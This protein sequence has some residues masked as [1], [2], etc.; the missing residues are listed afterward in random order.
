M[1]TIGVSVLEKIA[2]EKPVINSTSDLT[3]YKA[4][5]FK[6]ITNGLLAE[7]IGVQTNFGGRSLVEQRLLV[8]AKR[9]DGRYYFE[10]II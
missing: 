10:Q 1:R 4:F 5:Y 9:K 2:K 6:K 8:Y 7:C 3:E